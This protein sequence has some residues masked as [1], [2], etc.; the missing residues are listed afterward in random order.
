MVIGILLTF[1]AN[2]FS[3]NEQSTTEG[4]QA[5]EREVKKILTRKNLA[6]R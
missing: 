3:G 1:K 5:R 2:F 6:L 4:A